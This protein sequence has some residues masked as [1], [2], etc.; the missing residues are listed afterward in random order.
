MDP[1]TK[2]EVY[3][4]AMAAALSGETVDP[5]ELPAPVER[6]E[7]FLGQLAYQLITYLNNQ[8]E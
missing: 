3:L 7:M 8:G 6:E 4:T 1:V 2:K 5:S